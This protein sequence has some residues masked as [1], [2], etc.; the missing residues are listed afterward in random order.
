MAENPRI[1]FKE[2]LPI[3]LGQFGAEIGFESRERGAFSGNGI[4]VVVK[5]RAR[6]ELVDELRAF[7]AL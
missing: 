3:A 6:G 5:V 2:R 4:N 1:T 7:R